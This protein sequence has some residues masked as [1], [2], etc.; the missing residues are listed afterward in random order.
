M[1]PQLGRALVTPASTA[2]IGA[3]GAA[4]GGG[5]GK[6]TGSK[7]SAGPVGTPLPAPAA[8]VT[9]AAAGP[10]AGGAAAPAAGTTGAAGTIGAAG[11]ASGAGGIPKGP[12]GAGGTAGMIGASGTAPATGG[13][14]SAT[15]AAG[16][17]GAPKPARCSM[18]DGPP[19]GRGTAAASGVSV[20]AAP[21]SPA[22]ATTAAQNRSI[23]KAY[24]FVL[25]RCARTSR[26]PRNRIGAPDCCLEQRLL[27]AEPIR[28]TGRVVTAAYSSG[29]LSRRQPHSSDGQVKLSAPWLSWVM[30]S[31]RYFSGNS[32]R[33]SG[34]R[35]LT[36]TE[37]SA[38]V[39]SVIISPCGSSG[40][41]TW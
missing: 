41:A 36:R 5:P 35:P 26:D 31:S 8:F 4:G 19:V 2:G 38:R 23:G 40:N 39:T 22:P 13:P 25:A 14:G 33:H 27:V 24:S 20:N 11:G 6:I 1:P 9:G 12:A 10:T 15:G 3:G 34:K 18:H 21:H 16:S 30:R 32:M 17:G 28:G 37:F 29:D 7:V